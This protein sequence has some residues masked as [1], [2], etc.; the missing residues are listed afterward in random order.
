MRAVGDT[1][2]QSCLILTS[3]EKPTGLAQREG[4]AAP[5]RSLQLTGLSATAGQEV[6]KQQ[7]SLAR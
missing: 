3:R 7:G 1:P 6:V 2:H 5:V 4:K